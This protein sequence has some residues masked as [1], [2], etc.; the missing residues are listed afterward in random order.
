MGFCIFVMFVIYGILVKFDIYFLLEG[1][2]MEIY[3]RLRKERV[4]N[5]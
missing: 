4:V 1:I 3:V 5:Y 2:R